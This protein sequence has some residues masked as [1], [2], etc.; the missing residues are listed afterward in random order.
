M[1]QTEII[2]IPRQMVTKEML[3]SMRK[4]LQIQLAAIGLQRVPAFLEL[5]S[6]QIIHLAQ[7]LTERN[8]PRGTQIKTE[9]FS[10]GFAKC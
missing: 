4:G 5:N 10:L 9:D 3:N 7:K 2:C 6:D 1:H 8:Y